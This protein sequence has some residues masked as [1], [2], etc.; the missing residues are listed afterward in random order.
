MQLNA[1]GSWDEI[2]PMHEGSTLP[3][4]VR[5]K[6]QR[7]HPHACGEH[8]LTRYASPIK[9]GSSPRM[10]G[11]LGCVEHVADGVGIIPTHVGN[12][13]SAASCTRTFRDHPHACG[14]HFAAQSGHTTPEGSSPRMWGT[15]PSRSC[16]RLHRGI[17]PA[18]VGNTAVVASAVAVAR[19]H[20]HAC[21]E[22]FTAAKSS[23]CGQGSS[24]RMW[25]TRA[26]S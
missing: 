18:H 17:I 4:V 13:R 9:G 16:A 15:P 12:T 8:Y 24:P 23:R 11:T 1:D 25:G 3:G 7:D 20:P 2:I 26:S 5:R 6:W 19:D 21:G 14:E 22:H 10:W